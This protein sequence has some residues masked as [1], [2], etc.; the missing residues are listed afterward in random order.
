MNTKWIA[1]MN[2]KKVV[3]ALVLKLGSFFGTFLHK[4]LTSIHTVFESTDAWDKCKYWHSRGNC[5]ISKQHGPTSNF[6]L[7][8]GQHTVYFFTLTIKLS[9]LCGQTVCFSSQGPWS[10]KILYWTLN[11]GKS[12]SS[13]TIHHSKKDNCQKS[14]EAYLNS[15]IYQKAF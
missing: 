2:L 10:I 4:F 1:R 15:C 3:F 6:L 11:N 8:I 14:P 9:F 13:L 7:S 12:N 5:W